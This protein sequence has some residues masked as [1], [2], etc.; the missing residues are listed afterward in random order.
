MQWPELLISLPPL[1]GSLCQKAS[2]G[3]FKFTQVYMYPTSTHECNRPNTF[4]LMKNYISNLK[5]SYVYIHYSKY[6]RN[7]WFIKQWRIRSFANDINPTIT[8][9]S[10][11]EYIA[12]STAAQVTAFCVSTTMHT[13]SIVCST[14]VNIC[15]KIS[16]QNVIYL[17]MSAED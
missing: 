11:R 1:T 8:E 15:N 10:I 4:C 6:A 16:W 7:H 12:C 3:T 17:E 5:P 13:A 14:F 9:M 2:M